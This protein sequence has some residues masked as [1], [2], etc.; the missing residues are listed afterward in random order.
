MP[1]DAEKEPERVKWMDG[2]DGQIFYVNNIKLKVLYFSISIILIIA[3]V[4]TVVIAALCFF[5]V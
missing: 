2:K 1:H 3:T 4:Y 5:V